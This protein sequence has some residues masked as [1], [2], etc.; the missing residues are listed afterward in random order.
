MTAFDA[1]KISVPENFFVFPQTNLASF[2]ERTDDARYHNELFRNV[3]FLITDALYQPKIVIEINDQTPLSPERRERDE[4]V[5]KI[6]EEAGIPV[7]KFWTSYG[8]NQEYI[9]ERIAETLNT[10][11]VTRIHHFNIVTSTNQENAVQPPIAPQLPQTVHKKNGCYIATCVYGSYNCP[12]VWGFRRYRD[13]VLS[14]SW[15]GR[16][17]IHIYYAISP[18]FVKIFGKRQWFQ[19]FFRKKLDAMVKKLETE[20]FENTPYFGY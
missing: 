19:K 8:V 7:I 1:I 20:G 16:L 12:P 11:P 5:Q 18:A 10:L 6:C 13:K 17:F 15:Y 14:G 9:K 4:K 2:I 3:D